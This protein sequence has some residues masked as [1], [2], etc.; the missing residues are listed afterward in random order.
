[1]TRRGGTWARLDESV[2]THEKTLALAADL[3]GL[4]VPQEYAVDVAVSQLHRLIC[5]CIRNSD[6]GRI[7]HLS[8]SVFALILG[9]QNQGLADRLHAAW[10]SS[11]FIDWGGQ[12]RARLHD[13]EAY[14]APIL[15]HRGRKEREPNTRPTRAKRAP[16]GTGNRKPVQAPLPEKNP[17]TPQGEVVRVVFESWKTEMAHPQARLTAKRERLIKA[18]LRE[19]YP[20]EAI[21]EAIKGCKA[22]GFHQGQNDRAQVFDDIEL[23]CRSGEKVE[24]FQGILKAGGNGRSQAAIMRDAALERMQGDKHGDP[25]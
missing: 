15:R 19:G 13:F 18:R 16:P 14:A 23:I 10:S 17:P 7:G 25:R 5:W 22:S 24:Q 21:L 4:G 1:M 20:V 2:H 6:T 9:W 12:P 8:P 11:G 3:E